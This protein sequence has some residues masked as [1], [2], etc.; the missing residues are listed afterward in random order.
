VEAR[1]WFRL[2][3]APE[4]AQLEALLEFAA[5]RRARYPTFFLALRDGSASARLLEP[6]AGQRV[7][8]T[9]SDTWP[10]APAGAPARLCFYRLDAHAAR[11]LARIVSAEHAP[12]GALA[13][14]TSDKTHW[15]FASLEAARFHLHL[16]AEEQRELS[17]ALPWLVLAPEP[18]PPIKMS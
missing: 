3:D 18:D 14:L 17:R 13:I 2:T 10:S 6:L 4:G 7:T 15:L 16:T 1:S 5:A 12:R 9:V 11:L 8:E